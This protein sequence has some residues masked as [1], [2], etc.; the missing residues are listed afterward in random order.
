MTGPSGPIPCRRIPSPAGSRSTE[1]G[2][3]DDFAAKASTICLADFRY[4]EHA[5]CRWSVS[6]QGHNRSPSVELLIRHRGSFGSPA[7]QAS[8]T[9]TIIAF[10]PSPYRL[11]TSVD[12]E[13]FRNPKPIFSPPPP[14]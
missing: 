14:A 4:S 7:T 9:R 1:N 10:R 3:S 11:E 12:S 8:R 13:A 2:W 5:T 6:A